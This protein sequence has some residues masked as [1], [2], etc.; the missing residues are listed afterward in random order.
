MSASR[1]RFATRVADLL[2]DDGVLLLPT[3]PI[4]APKKGIGD[5]DAPALRE[6]IFRLTCLAPMLGFPEVTLPLATVDGCPIG[7]SLI[8]PPDGDAMLLAAAAR[9]G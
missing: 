3:V 9:A 2:G 7:L 1:R 5:A 8:G 4:I 6:R